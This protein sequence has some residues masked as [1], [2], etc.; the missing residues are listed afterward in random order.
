MTDN[1]RGDIS[2]RLFLAGAAGVAGT[3]AAGLV[4]G[5]SKPCQPGLLSIAGGSTTATG[6][7]PGVGLPS[8][9][10]TSSAASG[11]YGFSFGQAFRQSDVPTNSY[12]ACAAA[13]SFQADVRNRWPD[14]SV[15]YAVLSGVA[16]FTQNT[17][18]AFALSTTTSAP[19]GSAVPEPTSLNVTVTFT[20]AV[21]GS[22]TLQSCLGVDR[23][24]WSKAGAGR[25]RQIPGAVM[26]EFHYY[27][28]TTDAHVA[29][30]FYVRCYAN[31]ATEVETVV[32]NGWLN[33]AAPGERD[34]MVA[35]S[36][37]GT[38]TYSGTLSHYSHTRWS[39]VDWIGA[40]PQFTPTHDPTYLRAT[41]LVPNY[42]YT[43]PTATAFGGLATALIPTPFALGNWDAQMGDTGDSEPIGLLPQWECLYCVSA[44]SR[45]Y[46]ATIG[47]NRGSGRWPIHFRDETTGRVPLYMSYPSMTLTSGWGTQPP[48]PTGGSN[49]GWDIPHHPSNGYLA[50]L[51][52]G[53]WTQ[54]ESL[55]FSAFQT[56]IESNPTTRYGGGVLA[57][58]NAPLTT[59]GA[60]WSWRTMGQAA[61]ISPEYLAG[62]TP[63]TADVAAGNSFRKSVDDTATWNVGRYVNG[64]IDSGQY[65]NSIGWLGQYDQ[66]TNQGASNQ[67]WGGAWMVHFQINALA[68]ISDLGIAGITEANLDAMRDHAYDGVIRLIGTDSTWNYRRAGVYAIPYYLTSS[69]GSAPTFLTTAQAFAI[70]LSVDSLTALTSN[71]GDTL[72]DHDSNSDINPGGTSND[73]AGYWSLTLAALATAVDHGKN[74]AMAAY[75]KVTSASNYNP[76]AHGVNDDPKWGIVPRT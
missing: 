56:I 28:P 74:G 64:T 9:T 46:G 36:V 14:G 71:N 31:G 41:K 55:Q 69:S 43:S 40:T 18:K 13:R 11:T 12:V 7:T 5:A 54:M 15:K 65:V 58:I 6:C 76:V 63:A 10:I 53:R 33:V 3:T 32:E 37:G 49:G 59:R 26:S 73:A 50:Y 21:T 16:A 39:R 8:L 20:G 23:S 57:C 22:Y 42:G 30:W 34:Y 75:Q 2:R 4:W 66:Y 38:T 60:A 1:K 61:A 27:R 68:H 45:A 72:K 48:T 29:V 51:I 25:V 52:E 62:G 67:W 17:P 35:V 19:G 70:Y 44:D 24:T 47:N